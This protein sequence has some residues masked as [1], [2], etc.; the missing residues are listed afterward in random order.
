MN[1]DPYQVPECSACYCLPI[2]AGGCPYLAQRRG[3]KCAC[4]DFKFNLD[5]VLRLK[6]DELKRVAQL[7]QR[8]GGP[9][10]R[11][12]GGSPDRALEGPERAVRF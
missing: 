3:D 10:E 12:G 1:W 9:G 8:D 5:E 2:C 4:V 11:P 6:Y 7:R